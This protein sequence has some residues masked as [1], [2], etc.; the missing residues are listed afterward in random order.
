MRCM[1][2]SYPE[3]QFYFRDWTDEEIDALNAFL[4]PHTVPAGFRYL[5]LSDT[6]GDNRAGD[7]Q[8]KFWE[9]L[10]TEY[11][12][13]RFVSV[14]QVIKTKQ[15]TPYETYMKRGKQVVRL[16]DIGLI[17]S[18]KKEEEFRFFYYDQNPGGKAID[19]VEIL[20]WLRKEINVSKKKLDLQ[21]G[22][23]EEINMFKTDIIIRDNIYGNICVPD[24]IRHLID[25]K[26]FQRLRRIA[27]LATAGQV[28]PGAVQNRFSH[29]LGVYYLM[30]KIVA[31]F[32]KKLRAIG[33][34][35]SIDKTD[36]EAIL[37][38]ALL[39]DIGHG[40]FSHAFEDAGINR[41]NFN[42][43]YWTKQIILSKE[44]DINR[45]LREIWGDKFPDLVMSYID[46]RNEVKDGKF[47]Q[48]DYSQNGLNLKF[49]FASLVSSQLDAD[50]MDYLLRDS[51][52]C[53]VTYG[54]FDIE[55]LIE[56]MSIAINSEGELKVGVEEKYVSNVEEYFYARYLMYNNI[57]YHPFKIFTEKL[58]QEILRVACASYINGHLTS[59][60]LPP[61]LAE[62]FNHATM[63]LQDFCDLDDHVVMGAIQIWANLETKET[64]RLAML[65][66]YFLN[67]CG[68]R[69]LNILNPEGFCEKLAKGSKELCNILDSK[70]SRNDFIYCKKKIQMYKTDKKGD[71]YIIKGNGTIVRIQDIGGM[72]NL[73]NE[74][75]EL[76]HS[77]ELTERFYPEDKELIGQLIREF[78][79]NNS[80]EI[81]KKYVLDKDTN[82]DEVMKKI[83][84]LVEEKDYEINPGTPKYQED[85]YF[86]T[87]SGTLRKNDFSVRIRTR[88]EQKY[89][90][91]KYK[92]QSESNGEGGQLERFEAERTIKSGVL[93]ENAEYIDESVV[94]LL[95]NE[96]YG[97]ADLSERI[98]V[99]NNRQKYEIF[100]NGSKFEREDERY[101]L[102]LD[103]VT[104]QNMNNG[105]EAKEIQIEI[106]L[107]SVYETRINMKELTDAMETIDHLKSISESKYSRALRMTDNTE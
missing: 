14:N 81:E 21:E 22:R 84:A 39:H 3:Y 89:I 88:N 24:K 8:K 103:D 29:S 66:N 33:Y 91:C 61:I 17:S 50:R 43:E 101:E 97:I 105:Q 71:V 93:I 64:E 28:F 96:S 6:I 25:C 56:G 2:K 5:V 42:H 11:N 77:M 94:T 46:C 74:G 19:I 104:Y 26:E 82:K 44:T 98:K 35:K 106:E 30:D 60:E 49:I 15:F 40:P 68:Y 4:E 99:I 78:D 51:R 48:N 52:A 72:V 63:S 58:L 38:A 31:H 9:Y 57:Y 45:T 73:E 59:N 75:S 1:W 62:I 20:N 95:N 36:K 80:V 55:R 54:Q 85:V 70:S 41:D 67:R 47:E 34:E 69:K 107:K 16:E 92:I 13:K 18:V 12:L 53:G 76:Y 79:V 10:K 27:Q 102:V 37:V 87:D 32:D 65:C 7:W 83:I 90:T 23:Y 100:K 86:D